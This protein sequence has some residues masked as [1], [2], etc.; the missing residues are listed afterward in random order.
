MG[1]W[2]GLGSG[3][4][5]GLGLSRHGMAGPT[6]TIF[7]ENLHKEYRVGAWCLVLA[8]LLVEKKC[9]FLFIASFLFSLLF[10]VVVVVVAVA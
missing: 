9:F 7:R 2:L 8:C 4:G 1:A 3:P 5:L 10:V 6:P